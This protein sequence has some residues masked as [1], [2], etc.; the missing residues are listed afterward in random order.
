MENKDKTW[1]IFSK[2]LVQKVRWLFQPSKILKP[3]RVK[4]NWQLLIN[5]NHWIGSGHFNRCAGSLIFVLIQNPS[6]HYVRELLTMMWC[7]RLH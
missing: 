4:D 7:V 2:T 1:K 3:K 6:E 5:D